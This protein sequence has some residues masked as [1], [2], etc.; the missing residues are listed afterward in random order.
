VG[1]RAAL[2]LVAV[3]LAT[4]FFARGA[5]AA[6][7]QVIRWHQTTWELAVLANGQARPA[8]GRLLGR[9]RALDL[10]CV[11]LVGW[12]PEVVSVYAL[13]KID[14]HVAF[15][16]EGGHAAWAVFVRRGWR[17]RPGTPLWRLIHRFGDQ[18]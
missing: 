17:I 1:A 4:A 5:P 16:Q 10:Q 9:T 2:A 11:P 3:G 6:C 8:H 12:K 18:R 13:P 14:P 7:P 15:Y